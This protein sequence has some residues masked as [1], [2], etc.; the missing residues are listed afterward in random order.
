MTRRQTVHGGCCFDED[1]YRPALDA[2]IFWDARH[3]PTVIVATANAAERSDPQ[4]FDLLAQHVPATVLRCGEHPEELCL[5]MAGHAIRLSIASGTLLEGPVSLCH[6]LSGDRFLSTRIRAL[7]GFDNFVRHGLI[8]EL[9]TPFAPSQQRMAMVL[10]TMDGLARGLS[11]RQIAIALFGERSV[12]ADWNKP[13]DFL[14]SRVRRLIA[15]VTDLG[16]DAYLGLL[17]R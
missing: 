3:D 4:A 16:G 14:K 17:Q 15:Q 6:H 12:T 11:Q 13:S 10:A 5:A 1:P 7:R 9:P 2:D 8:S